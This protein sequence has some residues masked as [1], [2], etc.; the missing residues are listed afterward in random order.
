MML[1]SSA[2]DILSLDAGEV[3]VGG[4]YSSLIP[5]M[6]QLS[7]GMH[8]YYSVSYK[9]YSHFIIILPFPCLMFLDGS[10]EYY[11]VALIKKNTLH[12]VYNLGHLKGKKACFAGVG[13]QAGWNI[14]VNTV[15]LKLLRII[16]CI[17]I[18]MF[19]CLAYFQRFYEHY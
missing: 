2:A 6:Q 3:F 4:R 14:P 15:R 11:A 12:D 10:T 13:T 18:I 5:L 17:L 19:L 1:D 9:Y 16:S 8:I 7:E